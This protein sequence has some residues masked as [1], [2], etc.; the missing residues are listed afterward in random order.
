MGIKILEEGEGSIEEEL[1]ERA[2][3]GP[4]KGKYSTKYEV[5]CEKDIG[6]LL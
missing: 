4:K 3:M 5:T 1:L 6:R 2:G